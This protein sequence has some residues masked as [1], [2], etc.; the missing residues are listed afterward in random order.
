MVAVHTCASSLLEPAAFAV[1]AQ[2]TLCCC[3]MK[4]RALPIALKASF[5]VVALMTAASRSSGSV[6]ER[7]TVEMAQM[8][9][10]VLLSPARRDSSSAITMPLVCQGLRFAMAIMTVGT[11]AMRS[12]VGILVGSTTLSARTPVDV[13]QFLGSVMGT[14]TVQMVQMKILPFAITKSAIQTRSISVIMENAYQNCGTVT[15]M[16]TAVI[17]QM[18]QHTNAETAT[19]LLA[20]KNAPL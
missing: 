2:T 14:M 18:N 15:L 10:D 8:K 12:S 1:L 13:F 11:R 9:W 20:G 7:R 19:A 4:R 17:I 3:L 16:M 6:M 5:G